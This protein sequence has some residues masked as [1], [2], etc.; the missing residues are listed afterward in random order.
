MTMIKEITVC[1]LMICLSAFSSV[2]AA[3]TPGNKSAVVQFPQD[4]IDKS[5]QVQ[6][7][8]QSAP[9]PDNYGVKVGEKRDAYINNNEFYF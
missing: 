1:L 5:K 9:N 6:E 8:S 7:V 2:M 4:Y 3:E